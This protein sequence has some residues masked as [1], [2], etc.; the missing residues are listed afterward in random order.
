MD[1]LSETP[2]VPVEDPARAM[3][4]DDL[5]ADTTAARPAAAAAP[6]PPPIPE[7]L[8]APASSMPPAPDSAFEF[9]FDDPAATPAEDVAPAPIAQTRDTEPIAIA[10]LGVDTGMGHDD[11]TDPLAGMS[12]DP[13]MRSWSENDREAPALADVAESTHSGYDVSISDLDDSPTATD[14]G[15]SAPQPA[16]SGPGQPRPD[17]S[18]VMRDRIHET[19]EK[20]AW[21]AFADV[22][23][24]IVRQ[25]M[26]RVESIVWE[27]V[28]QMAET[29][30]QE[31]IRRMKGDD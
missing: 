29:L 25:V 12:Q 6:A 23:D 22:S 18:P 27:V 13:P 5:F 2:A 19:L 21:E 30:I 28:P 14:L 1:P 26:Q 15:I 7:P 20:I 10:D 16:A 9:G 11:S 24:S 4:A 31:E 8:A 17:V 3:P